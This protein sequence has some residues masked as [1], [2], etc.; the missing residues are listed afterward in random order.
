MC[1][2]LTLPCRNLHPDRSRGCHDVRGIPGMLRRHSGV[3]VSSGNGRRHKALES[4]G[5]LISLLHG[6]WLCL[7]CWGVSQ[8]V[9][10]GGCV[11]TKVGAG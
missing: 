5:T 3:S 4:L 1:L 7:P 11:S 9:G 8:Q 2:P 6:T 10:L